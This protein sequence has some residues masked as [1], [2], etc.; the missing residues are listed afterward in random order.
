MEQ[1]RYYTKTFIKYYKL[2]KNFIY[3]LDMS[4]KK[5]LF[6]IITFRNKKII[7]DR[8]NIINSLVTELK[9]LSNLFIKRDFNYF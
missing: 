1:Y 2:H 8:N 6:G 4:R 5:F 3:L 7:Y 9:F